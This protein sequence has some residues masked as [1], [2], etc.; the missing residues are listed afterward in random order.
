MIRAPVYL[1]ALPEGPEGAL[2]CR[3]EAWIAILPDRTNRGDECNRPDQGVTGKTRA[4]RAG[5]DPGEPVPT[6]LCPRPRPAAARAARRDTGSC[7]VR[8][9]FG[10]AWLAVADEDV[11]ADAA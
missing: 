2:E 1:R 5:E 8:I 10:A 11:L 9:G 6:T 7:G 4:A 3:G